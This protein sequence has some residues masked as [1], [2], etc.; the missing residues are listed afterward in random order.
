VRERLRERPLGLSALALVALEAAIAALGGSSP[1]LSALVLLMAPGLALLPL[2]PARARESSTAALA[3]APILGTAA[4]TV[5][6]ISIASTGAP[7]NGEIVRLTVAAIVVLGL[8]AIPDGEPSAPL[9][10]SALLGSGGLLVAVVAGVVLQERVIGGSPVPGNDWAKYV[11]YA[12]EVRIHGSLLIDNPFWMLGAPFREDPGVPALYGSYLSLTG[13]PASVLIH[14]IWV[15][16]V[17]GILST[18]AFVRAFWGDLAGALAAVFF[19]VLPINQNILGWHGLA[20]VAAIALLP[21]VLLYLGALLTEPF[22]AREGAGF[23]LVLVALLAMHRLSFVVGGLAVVATLAV[24]FA[25]GRRRHLLAGAL[26]T[27]GAAL[28]LSP[29]VLY[30]IVSRAR[31]FHGTQDY[32]AYLTSKVDLSLVSRDLTTVF[33]VASGV[34]VAAALLWARRDLRLLPLLSTLAVAAV[35]AYAWVAHLPLVYLRMPYFLPVALAPLVAIAMTRV[36]RPSLAALAGVALAVAVAASAWGQARN[37]HDFYA[38]ANATSLRG[39]DGVTARLRPR[40]VVVT[41]RCWSFLATWLLHTRTL[42]ALEP[43]DIQPKAEVAR[44]REARAVLAGTPEGRALARRL[45]VRFL[46][47]DPTCTDAHGR[48]LKP[49]AVGR[50][51]FVSDR[52]V[53]LVR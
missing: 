52:L 51:V 38:F 14:G 36:L 6:L 16:A 31:T 27:A 11:L 20:N 8:V 26:A 47:V 19:A 25:L 50:P 30:D 9:S 4:S 41:D 3:A 13:E 35:L 33:C 24:A 53:V 23:G 1:L 40:E 44:A 29:G 49:P 34:A 12:D 5:G 2:L 48:P 28:V 15:F 43:V 7:L 17:M 45:G 21:G 18:F 22:R 42:P 39:L 46:V 32:T 10:R 37:V